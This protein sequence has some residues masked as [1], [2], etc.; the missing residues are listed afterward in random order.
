M[1]SVIAEVE[2]TVALRRVAADFA[3]AVSGF[4]LVALDDDVRKLAGQLKVPLRA[5]DAIHVGTALA[6][7]DRDL[8]FVTYDDRMAA[9][10]HDAGLRVVRPGC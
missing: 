3:E 9:A 7:G 4:Y 5:L 6:I 10:A 8:E 2:V 1:T